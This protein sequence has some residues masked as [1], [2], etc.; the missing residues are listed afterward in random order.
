MLTVILEA[1]NL[2]HM[3][4]LLLSWATSVPIPLA[5]LFDGYIIFLHLHLAFRQI[6]G[7]P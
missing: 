1:L 4:I 3:V 5:M 6:P 2:F 7:L